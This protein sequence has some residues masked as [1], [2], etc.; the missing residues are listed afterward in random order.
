M[1]ASELSQR[2]AEDPER[3]ARYLFPHGKREGQEWRV[4]SVNGEKGRSMGI[5]LA[6]NKKG[7]WADFATGE[8]GDLL[9]LWANSKNL[10]IKDAIKEAKDFLGIYNTRF[11]G[12]APKAYKKP[13]KPK[14]TTPKEGSPVFK[15]LTEE[16]KL[17]PETIAAY[18]VA[19]GQDSIVF[20]YLLNNEPRMIK[21]L[22]LDRTNG[23]KDIRPTSSEQE[24]CLF[25]WQA[26]PDN[27]REVTICEGEIDAMSSF[28][29]GYPAL[30]VP[31]G[32]GKGAKHAWIENEFENLERF[33]RIYLCFDHDPEGIA[34]SQEVSE[35]LG[36]FRCKIV[37]L[38]RKDINDC[39]RADLDVFDI[40]K[41]FTEA[42]TL[43]PSEL[44]PASYF[45][46][47]VIKEFYP[48]EGWNPGFVTPWLKVGGK[49]RFRPGEV[50]LIAG[51][52]GQGKSEGTGHIVLG[53]MKQGERACIAS[54]EFH[55]RKW[56]HRIT[57]QASGV[58]E[59][60]ILYIK[61]IQQWFNKKLWVFDVVGTAKAKR[62]LE[63]FKYARQRYGIQLFVIDNLSKLD[64]GFED[65]DAQRSFIDKLTDF[66]KEFDSHVILVC[67]AR[68]S[69]DESKPPGKMDIKGTGA[70]TDLVQ[71][72]L[73][74]WRNKPKEKQIRETRGE[75]S[76]DILGK[77]DAYVLCDKQNNGDAEPLIS[78]WFDRA[79]HQFLESH[80]SR[81]I[82]YVEFNISREE[83]AYGCEEET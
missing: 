30:S 10:S 17:T 36:R 32:G 25:G 29:Y 12:Q 50:S 14:C 5:H 46:A 59:P 6:G 23:K 41:Y 67:H 37:S 49:L 81:P 68:K 56:L 48:P 7:V 15:Y 39:L 78:L 33:D 63:V 83:V 8:S 79:S 19:D 69:I 22:K 52:N 54:L 40:G 60:T 62:I 73:I 21:R 72:V 80:G 24:P 26:I 31:Y 28:Q 71:T 16:R 2:L 9:D 11:H 76:Q 70:L 18:K 43:D 34:A 51:Y 65:Y 13:T 27:S 74:W 64:I 4:G 75:V 35:R 77:P 53:A 47:D 42:R 44:K 55:P 58:D 1:N 20:P 45:D 61:A 3:I 38:P 66:S 82:K 57:R